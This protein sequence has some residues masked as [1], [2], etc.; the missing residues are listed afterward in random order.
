MAKTNGLPSDIAWM[1]KGA[2]AWEVQHDLEARPLPVFIEGVPQHL[3]MDVWRVLVRARG[4]H[5]AVPHAANVAALHRREPDALE[6][7][8]RFLRVRADAYTRM[9]DSLLKQAKEVSDG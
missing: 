3:G 1:V 9:A 6:Q 8:A 2:H 4:P 7:A 5:R